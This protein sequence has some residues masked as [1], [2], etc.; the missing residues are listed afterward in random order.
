MTAMTTTALPAGV[1]TSLYTAS[2]PITITLQNVGVA[3]LRVR[4]GIT[5]TTGDALTAAYDVLQ[6]GE[7]R[8]VTLVMSDVVM[9]A[10]NDAFATTGKINVRA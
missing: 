9:A 4:I 8:S 7:L 5:V 10:V 6:P 3:V 2:V 1:W